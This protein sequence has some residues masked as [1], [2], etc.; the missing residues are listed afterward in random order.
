MFADRVHAPH[1]RRSEDKVHR[2]SNKR[3][4][5]VFDCQQLAHGQTH[6]FIERCEE[7]QIARGAKVRP[8]IRAEYR[9]FVNVVATAKLG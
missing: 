3:R 5:L 7:V 9:Q 4:E 2:S 8:Q 6:I 1:E